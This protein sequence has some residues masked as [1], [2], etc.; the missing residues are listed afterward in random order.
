M[1]RMRQVAAFAF[2]RP[3]AA[4]L[5]ITDDEWRLLG[6]LEAWTLKLFALLIVCSDFKTGKG[7]TGYDE[8]ITGMTPDQPAAGPRLWAPSRM[9]VK[10]ALYRFEALGLA[11]LDRDANK[12]ARALFFEVLPRT[13]A[14]MPARKLDRKLDPHFSQVK[15]GELD[16]QTR[17]SLS[18]NKD[19]KTAHEAPVD[20]RPSRARVD[21]LRAVR[22][23]LAAR[24]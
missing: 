11:S 8:L 23:R 3:T 16:P 13:G 7:R 2:K 18:E 17:P 4:W 22:G 1:A 5:L 21:A 12:P 14:S 9:D 6:G 10:R 20:N 15:Q 24:G 19:L